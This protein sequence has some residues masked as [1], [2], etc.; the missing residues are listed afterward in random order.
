MGKESREFQVIPND[1]YDSYYAAR[2][3]AP[4]IVPIC[5]GFDEAP[6]GEKLKAVL[7]D[8]K[9]NNHKAKFIL[10]GESHFAGHLAKNPSL[11]IE[12]AKERAIQD[13]QKWLT[14]NRKA[15]GITES[16]ITSLINGESIKLPN[17]DIQLTTLEQ[18]E[19]TPEFKAAAEAYA[20]IHQQDT[21]TEGLLQEAGKGF[22]QRNKKHWTNIQEKFLHKEKDLDIFCASYIAKINTAFIAWH[23]K[24]PTSQTEEKQT[25]TPPCFHIYNERLN[26]EQSYILDHSE[27]LEQVGY[28]PDTL[29]PLEYVT[30][31]VNAKEKTI[32]S[33]TKNQNSNNTEEKEEKS[34][35]THKAI[36]S[37]KKPTGVRIPSPS[38]GSNSSSDSPTS[39]EED[40]SEEEID[41][42]GLATTLKA[43]NL[44][45][46]ALGSTLREMA[47]DTKTL[48]DVLKRTHQKPKRATDPGQG[49]KLTS[50]SSLKRATAPELGSNFTNPANVRQTMFSSDHAAAS[51]EQIIVQQ[52]PS[53]QQNTSS[54]SASSTTPAYTYTP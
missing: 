49:K 45:N 26:G 39:S 37:S 14:K 41:S 30:K 7:Q 4:A 43:M 47:L 36:S 24:K 6:S 1:R 15:L 17:C 52:T 31:R 32:S 28:I 8:L 33:S 35:I 5:C 23:K 25:T 27:L 44:P 38:S 3:G 20:K 29:I 40:I 10:I 2:N 19:K 21:L 46:Q 16:N 9:K 22:V 48:A 34:Q 42:E 18:E 13:L 12:Q 54:S 53:L 11:T 51:K 50:Y